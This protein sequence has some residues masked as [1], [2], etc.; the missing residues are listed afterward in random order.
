MMVPFLSIRRVLVLF[1]MMSEGRLPV[2][3]L[4]D[5]GHEGLD[6][7]GMIGGSQPGMACRHGL[8]PSMV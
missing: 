2:A 6:V 4:Q 8:Q 7:C 5:V 1:S 3:A